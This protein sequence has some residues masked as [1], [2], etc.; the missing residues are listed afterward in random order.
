VLLKVGVR[1]ISYIKKG[2]YAEAPRKHRTDSNLT[3]R[4]SWEEKGTRGTAKHESVL[5]ISQGK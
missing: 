1:G 5:T 2:G 3:Q 4:S